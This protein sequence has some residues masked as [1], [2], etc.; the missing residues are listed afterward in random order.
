MTIPVTCSECGKEGEI[1]A[2]EEEGNTIWQ[3]DNDAEDC[4]AKN[5]I[6]AEDPNE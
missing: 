5:T 4:H 6:E 1:G 2:L 3:C